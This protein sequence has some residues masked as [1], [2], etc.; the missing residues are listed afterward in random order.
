MRKLAKALYAIGKSGE[1]LDSR[2]LF[3]TARLGLAP[4]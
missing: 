4:S 3:D 1:P 2:K